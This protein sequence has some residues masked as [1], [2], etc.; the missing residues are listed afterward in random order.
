VSGVRTPPSAVVQVRAPCT[1]LY[2]SVRAGGDIQFQARVEIKVQSRE[3]TD[4][5]YRPVTLYPSLLHLHSFNI[6]KD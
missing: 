4:N 1:L 5:C 2:E 6:D 3:I